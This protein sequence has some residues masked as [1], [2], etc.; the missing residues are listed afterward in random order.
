[1]SSFQ[2]PHQVL[3]SKRNKL[4]AFGITLLLAFTA[5]YMYSH[6]N[7]ATKVKGDLME[8]SVQAY[9]VSKKDMLKKILFSGETVPIAQIDLSPKYAGKIVE[10]NV[11]LG[12]SVDAG[13]VLLVQDTMDPELTIDQDQA[14]YQQAAADTRT[15]ESQ[16]SSELQK[17]QVDYEVAQ[18]NYNRYIVL[19]SEGAISQKDLDTVYQALIAAKSTLDNLQTQNVGDTPAAIVSKQAAQAKAAYVIDSMK[20]QRDDLIIRAPR[21]GIISYRNAEVG[22]MASANTKVLSITD[23]SVIYID[24]P[25]SE[26]DVASIK[27]G[28]PVSVSIESLANTYTGT[29]TYVSP[30][31][32]TSTK[33]YIIRITLDNPDNS[34]RG[35]MFAQSS[36]KVLQRRNTL[37]V[38]KDALLEINGISKLYIITTNNKIEIRQVKT[39][40]R[41]DE[42][43]EILEG[44][45]DGDLIATSNTARL[46]DGTNVT[47]EKEIG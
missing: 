26:A 14:A 28:I 6:Y 15:A 22:S 38:P 7:T 47:I 20:K 43:V 31:M 16:F 9:R 11:N 36:V 10:V 1:M 12:D 42:Y 45:S 32:D 24:C 3:K 33:T 37:Y 44:L 23:N 17:A 34:L 21:A 29:N 35:G 27:P 40:L 5:I 13:Q 41:N 19:K 18:M 4:I 8:A 25:L 30:T 46:K 39:G 2:L